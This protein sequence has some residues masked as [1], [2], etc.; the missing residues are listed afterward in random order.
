MQQSKKA[1][2]QTAGARAKNGE[3]GSSERLRQQP[4]AGFFCVVWRQWRSQRGISPFCR[5]DVSRH[6][7]GG[8]PVVLEPKHEDPS[9]FALSEA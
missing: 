3:C 5:G 7:I 9:I 6:C 4:Y 8:I 1:C 2:R